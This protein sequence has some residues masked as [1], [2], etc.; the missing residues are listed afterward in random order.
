VRTV[1]ASDI[2]GFVE[3]KQ[4]VF[5]FYLLDKQMILPEPQD[6]PDDDDDIHATTTPHVGSDVSPSAAVL[7]PHGVAA[8]AATTTDSSMSI[9]SRRGIRMSHWTGPMPIHE[10]S[11]RP[12]DSSATWYELSITRASCP[13]RITAGRPA[14]TPSQ[15]H[16]KIAGLANITKSHKQ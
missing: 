9:N 8:A 10:T 14:R 5:N 3:R 4:N 16:H 13:G 6:L 12:R 15:F 7:N 11:E 2:Q 1:H